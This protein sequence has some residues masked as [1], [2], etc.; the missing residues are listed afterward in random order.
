MGER[1]GGRFIASRLD[2][3]NRPPLDRLLP[4]DPLDPLPEGIPAGSGGQYVPWPMLLPEAPTDLERRTGATGSCDR[5]NLRM[6]QVLSSVSAD[7]EFRGSSAEFASPLGGVKRCELFQ[8]SLFKIEVESSLLHTMSQESH[9]HSDQLLW[10]NVSPQLAIS[11][12]SGVLEPGNTFF[13][14]R[15]PSEDREIWGDNAALKS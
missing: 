6:R 2:M 4:A 12:E 13:N 10:C 8:S 5:P 3:I 7:P 15:D 1:S 14:L 11:T 9:T